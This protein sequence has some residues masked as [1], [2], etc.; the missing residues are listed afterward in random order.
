MSEIAEND[1]LIAKFMGE[2]ML[3][4]SFHVK[5]YKDICV[6]DGPNGHLIKEYHKDWGLLIPV[7]ERI[8]KDQY[9]DLGYDTYKTEEAIR[10]SACLALNKG[11]EATNKAVI[12]FIKC[13]NEN[14]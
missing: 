13:Y 1:R 2:K 4:N 6:V 3:T 7:V 10:V 12:E 5:K 8:L 9:L 11:I 14:K